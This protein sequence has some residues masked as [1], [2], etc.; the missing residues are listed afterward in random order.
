MKQI[1]AKEF[2]EMIEKDPSVFEHWDTPLEIT[3]PIS[4]NKSP[5]THLSRHLTF[6]KHAEFAQ[7]EDLEIATGNFKGNVSFILSGVK[8][9][10]NL[11]VERET[12]FAGCSNLKIATGNFGGY[13][14]FL[15]SGIQR[16]QNLKIEKPG[17]DGKYGNFTNCPNL[18]SLENWDISKPIYIEPEKFEA[19]V[20][21]RATLKKFIR[22]TQAQ[23]LPFL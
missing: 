17:E 4:C 15:E 9:I 19:E 5:I 14:T 3:E 8:K 2:Y 12:T 11:Y 23:K 10:E 22:E 7:C 20:K 6:H 18:H 1:T 21:R 13:V 16:I